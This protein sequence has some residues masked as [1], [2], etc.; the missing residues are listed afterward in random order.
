MKHLSILVP[1]GHQNLSSVVG[2]F[3][4][5]SKA[6]DHYKNLNGK[7]VFNIELVSTSKT[8]KLYRGIFSVNTD[9]HINEI[10]K[11]DLIIVPAVLPDFSASIKDVN[12]LK[13]W[14]I[15]MRK[16]GAEIASICTGVF[17]LAHAGLIEGRNCS[18]HWVA[19]DAFKEMF[20]EINLTLDK[21]I[22]D[23][24]G[25]YT[26]GGA[27]S[28]LNLLLYLVEKYFDRPTAIYCSKLFQIDLDRQSQSPFVIFSAQKK[29]EDEIIKKAQSLIEKNL[30]EKVSTAR[31]SS[32]LSLSRRN[33]DR[34]FRKATGNTPL[35]YSQRVRIE[36]AKRYLET[37]RKTINEVMYEVG[38]SD[39]KA[40]R[41]IFRKITGISPLDYRNKYN[42]EAPPNFDKSRVLKGVLK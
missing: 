33:F 12:Q 13:S 23:E 35:E 36:A 28:F 3:E 14:L 24:N 7:T 16:G 41:E 19:A 30:K 4:V 8:V 37:S 10:K 5:F 2:A 11:S 22:T 38:Y 9:K 17:L 40:F 32:E 39:A 34:R 1:N 27:F 21:V 25:I 42:K 26:N 29:H 6:N 18:T 20:P 15:K 31:L